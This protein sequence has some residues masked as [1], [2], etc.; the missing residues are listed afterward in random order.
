MGR[1]APSDMTV[2]VHLAIIMDGNGRWAR[3]RGMPRPLGHLEGTKRVREI[4]HACRRAGIRYLTLFA[5]STE[6]WS[7]PRAE[8]SALMRQ[9]ERFLTAEIQ[10]IIDNNIR[11]LII[12][13][14]QGLTEKLIKQME[15]AQSLTAANTGL[16]LVLAINYGG[17]QEIVE[18]ARMYAADVEKGRRESGELDEK[19]FSSYLYTADIPDPDFLIRTSGETRISNFLLWQL[20]YAEMYFPKKYWPDFRESDLKEALEE[21]FLRTRRFGK[22]EGKAEPPKEK[23]HAV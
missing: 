17:R 13:G 12:G 22:A 6:N 5:F 21:Y 1:P 20:S 9:L 15:K 7:R 16:T 23:R 2:P 3:E 8:V 4:V 18:A 14:K 19:V 11:L 10:E